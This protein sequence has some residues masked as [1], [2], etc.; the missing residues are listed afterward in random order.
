MDVTRLHPNDPGAWWTSPTSS[1][2]DVPVAVPPLVSANPDVAWS[3]CDSNYAYSDRRR[4][5][6]TNHRRLGISNRS[7]Q[8]QYPA[9]KDASVVHF[10][11]SYLE[12]S[13]MSEWERE[14][15]VYSPTERVNWQN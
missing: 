11:I 1:H 4:W 7:S 6:N 3:R 15:T 12:R 5:R 10:V 8:Q 13:N 2:P 9:K 14:L